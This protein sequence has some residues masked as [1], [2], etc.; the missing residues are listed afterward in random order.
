MVLKNIFLQYIAKFITFPLSILIYSIVVKNFSVK[1]FAEY[2]LLLAT[3]IYL[4]GFMDFGVGNYF[5]REAL[6]NQK[7]YYFNILIN[8]K[9]VFNIFV[10]S[11]YFLFFN[12]F[13]WKLSFFLV[14]YIF[15]TLLKDVLDKILKSDS[16][17]DSIAYLGVFSVVLQF[18]GIVLLNFIA[19]LNIYTV[20]ALLII[21]FIVYDYLAARKKGKI[22]LKIKE[23][24]FFHS[25]RF[26][27]KK[28]LTL[29]PWI[30]IFSANLIYSR[31]DI[32]MLD[33][34]KM[35]YGV[36]EY[37]SSYML[38]ERLEFLLLA[39]SMVFYNHFAKNKSLE[40]FSKVLDIISFVGLFFVALLLSWGDFIVDLIIGS[41]YIHATEL[42][43]IMVVGTYFKFHSTF[44]INWLFLHKKERSAAIGIV[45][46]LFSNFIL[47]LFVIPMYGTIGAAYT[48]LLSDFLNFV[49][50]F[51]FMYY[52]KFNFASKYYIIVN[53][54]YISIVVFLFIAPSKWVVLLPLLFIEM[55]YLG[56]RYKRYSFL[57]GLV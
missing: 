34:F 30:L 52:H 8:Y 3:A 29:L 56:F 37:S 48:T 54:M 4:L 32:F 51:L 39:V 20:L 36:A 9:F 1:E 35:P 22:A 12:Q 55:F 19:A 15:A 57:K 2:N 6:N 50:L 38:Y 53:C 13:D 31:L 44:F 33:F 25:L 14:V 10:L 7:K 16:R 40:L 28:I 21:N 46:M 45:L 11:I 27:R 24:Y 23:K 5:Y 26:I 17:F 41:K 43:S 49:F 42:F 47:N 18:I